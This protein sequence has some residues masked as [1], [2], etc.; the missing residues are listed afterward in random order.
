MPEVSTRRRTSA[1]GLVLCVFYWHPLQG[2]LISGL[3]GHWQVL[4][5]NTGEQ[6]CLLLA[7]R[8]GLQHGDHHL[9]W[10]PATQGRHQKRPLCLLKI[11]ELVRSDEPLLDVFVGRLRGRALHQELVGQHG[12]HMALFVKLGLNLLDGE[13]TLHLGEPQR[14]RLGPEMRQL[15]R[16]LNHCV[17]L[18]ALFSLRHC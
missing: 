8:A 7:A 6:V 13:G 15:N 17:L 11:R 9:R 10:F 5:K 16:L 4:Q 1:V 18:L 12:D 3:P 14:W 2:L